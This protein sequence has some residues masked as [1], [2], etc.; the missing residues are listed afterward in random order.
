MRHSRKTA[1]LFLRQIIREHALSLQK[2]SEVKSQKSIL[3]DSMRRVHSGNRE[4]RSERRQRSRRSLNSALSSQTKTLGNMKRIRERLL[5]DYIKT[6][7]RETIDKELEANPVE[8]RLLMALSLPM[9]KNP[10]SKS[11]MKLKGIRTGN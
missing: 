11:Y 4:R 2:S 9:L 10:S 6:P 3:K 1:H 7:Y 5:N 8:S